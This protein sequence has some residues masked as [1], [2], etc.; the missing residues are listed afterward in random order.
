MSFFVVVSEFHTYI[1]LE[2]KYNSIFFQ[3]IA[4]GAREASRFNRILRY[5]SLVLVRLV[6]SFIGYFLLSVGQARRLKE[7]NQHL[8]QLFYS[9]LSLAFNI[10]LTL[11]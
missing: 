10:N 8:F 4:L 3:I 11:K 5:R 2:C 9:L 6:S 1:F 7:V